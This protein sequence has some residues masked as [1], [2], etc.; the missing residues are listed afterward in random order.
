MIPRTALDT[1]QLLVHTTVC[2]ALW[3]GVM[4]IAPTPSAQSSE[5][6]APR[7]RASPF[8]TALLDEDGV[9]GE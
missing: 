9:A 8:L 2:A 6:D 1:E 7:S 4:A 5:N 3:S